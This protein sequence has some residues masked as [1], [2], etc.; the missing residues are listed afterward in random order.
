MAGIFII[1]LLFFSIVFAVI[2]ELSIKEG[3]LRRIDTYSYKT[4]IK[5]T[6]RLFYTAIIITFVVYFFSKSIEVTISLGAL[7]LFGVIGGCLYGF[8]WEYQTKR[9]GGRRRD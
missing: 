3:K 9:R 8:L 1:V 6:I 5:I 2:V 7:L 4:V